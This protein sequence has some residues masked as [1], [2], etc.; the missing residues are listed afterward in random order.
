LIGFGTLAT[1]QQAEM[2]QAFAAGDQAKGMEIWRQVLPLEDAVFAQPVRNY[3]ARTKA[4]LHALGVIDH[5]TVRPPLLPC[6][7]E[8]LEPVLKHLNALVEA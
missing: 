3:R 8:E 5:P 4:A 7:R 1:A 6:S 2:V